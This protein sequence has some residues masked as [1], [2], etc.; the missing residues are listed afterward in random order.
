M[1]AAE[2]KLGDDPRT[3][4][5]VATDLDG[6][7]LRDD[8]S[9]SE[10]TRRA[11][12]AAQGVGITVVLVTGRPPRFVQPLAP[13]L[14]VSG[15]A[16][17]CNGA[18]L[19]DPL[20]NAVLAH[21]P[22]TSEAARAVVMRMRAAS[23]GVGFAIER[24]LRYGCDQTYRQLGG[25]RLRP[26]DDEVADAL[27]LCAQDVTKLI[28]RHPTLGSHDFYPQARSLA[29]D[30]AA[31]TISGPH[32]VELNALGVDKAAMLAR[33]C[34]RLAIAPAQVMAFGDMPNDAPMLAWA[35]RGVAVANAHP[36]ARAAADEH[37]ASNMEDGVAQ[38][39]EQLMVG[40]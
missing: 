22:M 16:I 12:E 31:V 15:P 11:L 5:L 17:C 3:V 7:L 24:E 30:I 23:P 10:R 13:E 18:L 4:R 33:L 25:G 8:Q 21:A 39:L 26:E 40:E 28:V 9:V 20:T 38:A 14:G 2:R 37:T 32:I 1:T 35:G 19:Y 34:A 36:E 29:S 27:T 6:T